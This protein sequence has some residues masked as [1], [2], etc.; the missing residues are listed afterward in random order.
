MN[1]DLSHFKCLKCGACCRQK[2]YVRLEKS[3]PD[4]I[5]DFLGMDVFQFIEIYTILTKDR[6]TLSLKEEADGACIFLTADG[7][8]INA[9]K[10]SQCLD[11][12]LKW[13]FTEM[14]AICA[15]AIKKKS[16]P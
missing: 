5:A 7:C 8:R 10:P 6:Q 9:V 13:K 4:R 3:D 1:A 14:D 11:F 2:G 15:W 12:P 16:N